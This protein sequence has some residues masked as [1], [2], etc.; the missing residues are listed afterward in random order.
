MPFAPNQLFRATDANALEGAGASAAAQAAAAALAA[1]RAQ[2]DATAAGTAAAAA[3]TAATAAQTTATAAQASATNAQA[4]ATTAQTSAAAASTAATAA[5]TDAANALATA[6][7]AALDVAS[8]KNSPAASLSF[9]GLVSATSD[10]DAEAK[11]VQLWHAYLLNGVTFTIRT[12]SVQSPA[13]GGGSVPGGGTAPAP[14]GGPALPTGWV[15]VFEDDFTYAT[16]GTT[17]VAVLDPSKWA[18]R[19]FGTGPFYGGQLANGGCWEQGTSSLKGHVKWNGSAWLLDGFQQG[20]QN[21]SPS[22]GGYHA[23]YGQFHCQFK[24]RFSHFY[25]PGVGAYLLMWPANNLWGTEIDFLE[26]PGANKNRLMVTC[27]R[28]L[29]GLYDL[30]D[31]NDTPSINEVPH[32]M[33][34]WTTIDA[35]RTYTTINGQRRATFRQWIN[36]IEVGDSTFLY[37]ADRTD[38]T[39]VPFLD[40]P[41]VFGAAGMVNSADW[42]APP[43]FPSVANGTP[44]DSWFELD[45]VRI[46]TPSGGG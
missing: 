46:W 15:Q 20:T 1:S 11:G 28:D 5:K 40:E 34:A 18:Q 31:G 9:Q 26:T 39:D 19:T 23:G 8:V 33:T 42:Y 36:G 6:K 43:G 41:M 3:R 13:Q 29:R 24:I 7:Q 16:V 4:T 2:A 25:S 12:T 21:N 44:A 17:G 30:N 37:G 27:H 35:R 45:Y 38:W 14:T 32:D 10:A 22:S